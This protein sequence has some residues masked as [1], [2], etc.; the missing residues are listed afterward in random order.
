MKRNLLKIISLV[1][2]LVLAFASCAVDSVKSSDRKIVAEVGEYQV[3]EALY[4]YFV[5]GFRNQYTGGSE[6]AKE[7]EEALSAKIKEDTKSSLINFFAVYEIAKEYGITPDSEDVISAANAYVEQFRLENSLT[8]DGDFKKV[9]K[10]N[11]MT[12]SVFK[13]TQEKTAIEHI[14]YEKLCE[15]GTIVTD[16]ND[17]LGTLTSG[18]VI[19]VTHILIPFSEGEIT[20][21]T[22]I[23][24]GAAKE[25]EAY[26]K[27]VSAMAELES[28]VSFDTLISKYG[29]DVSLFNNPDGH[30]ISKGNKELSYE[31]AAFSLSVNETSD[32]VETSKGF[33]I[34]KRLESDPMY[35]HMHIEE[36]A[37]SY[38]E[39]QFNIMAEEA[40][41]HL[42][43]SYK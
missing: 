12:Y 18:G 31:E 34:I 43:F 27:A 38:A 1:C 11:D 21:K 42:T 39:G 7:D 20:Y 17:L 32:I 28:G 22:I 40:A 36:L 6:V 4:N 41:S 19:R 14:L 26:A 3:S 15:N 33:C 8:D 5:F 24:E 35:I 10:A 29:Q 30:Y 37:T 25:T 16:E 9:L 23:T 13:K 2:V